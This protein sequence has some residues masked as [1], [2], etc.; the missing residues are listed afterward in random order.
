[1][2]RVKGK[3]VL[4]H[5]SPK[6]DQND[7]A[8]QA[9]ERQCGQDRIERPYEASEQGMV[10]LLAV[11]EVLAATYI[12]EETGP[13]SRCES[14]EEQTCCGQGGPCEAHSSHARRTACGMGTKQ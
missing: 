6:K 4:P 2:Q 5:Q 14:Y 11:D 7:T 13:G 1:M 3:P 10:F 8:C 9:V 12:G